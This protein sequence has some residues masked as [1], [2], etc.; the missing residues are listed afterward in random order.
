MFGL[1]NGYRKIQSVTIRKISINGCPKKNNKKNRK[2]VL[3]F[4]LGY[5]II[6]L[7][8]REGIKNQKPKGVK[9]MDMWK[10]EAAEVMAD[11]MEEVREWLDFEAD[12]AEMR[13]EA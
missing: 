4:R 9:I 13:G 6:Q 10:M 12:V 8:R 7:S 11:A 2:K 1:Q 5:A 3:T